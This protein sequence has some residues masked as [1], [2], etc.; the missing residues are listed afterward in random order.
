MLCLSI[1]DPEPDS[2]KSFSDGA[3]MVEKPVVHS[4][5]ESDDLPP[6]QGDVK[7]PGNPLGVSVKTI[8]PALHDQVNQDVWATAASSL[9]HRPSSFPRAGENQ[10]QPES[11]RGRSAGQP[12]PSPRGR[13]GSSQPDSP[14]KGGPSSILGVGSKLFSRI[15]HSKR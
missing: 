5:P 13:H 3:E 6:V 9:A 15:K 2:E 4:S 14:R 7:K 10:R 11:P 1:S 12:E 8:T